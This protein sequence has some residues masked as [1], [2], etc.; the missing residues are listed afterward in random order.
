MRRKLWHRNLKRLARFD[1]L[2]VKVIAARTDPGSRDTRDEF[3]KPLGAALT[4]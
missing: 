1:V 3:L 2:H 4:S